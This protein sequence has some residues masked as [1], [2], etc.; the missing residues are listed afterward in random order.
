MSRFAYKLV[1]IIVFEFVTLGDKT[2]LQGAGAPPK[3]TFAPLKCLENYRKINRNN[4]LSF[5]NNGL[6]FFA[7]LKF[8]SKQKASN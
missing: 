1:L 6:L 5:K 2:L 7:L 4:R 8:L 3:T